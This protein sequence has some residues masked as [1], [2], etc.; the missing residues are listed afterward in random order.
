MMRKIIFIVMVVIVASTGAF[1]LL[2]KPK[3]IDWITY[4]PT[5][6]Q[7][8]PIMQ[9]SAK[10]NENSVIFPNRLVGGGYSSS[11]NNLKQL[12]F[13]AEW[14]EMLPNRGW[15]AEFSIPMEMAPLR[16]TGNNHF[17][18]DMDIKFGRNGHVQLINWDHETIVE[19][20]GVRAP[21]L[22]KDYRDQIPLDQKIEWAY[23]I[24][25]GPPPETPCP[26]PEE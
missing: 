19:T 1:V 26:D 8:W 12:F 6:Y 4:S 25:D 20:C 15:L 16:A 22:D 24:E 5:E 3:Q 13:S 11:V 10:L 14:V 18:L 7:N 21:N 2:Y 17:T 23:K 9:I